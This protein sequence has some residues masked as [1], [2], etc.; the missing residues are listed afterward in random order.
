MSCNV[1][2]ASLG[3][4]KNRVDAEMMLGR[5]TDSGFR[6][7][8]DETLADV[9]IVNTCGFIESAKSESIAEILDIAK[10]KHEGN[11]KGLVVTGCLAQRY[12]GQLLLEMPEIDAVLGL[13]ANGD[14]V[15]CVN[16]V[17]RGARLE[18]FPEKTAM[19]LDGPRIL[20]T[21]NHYAY[22]RVAEG[23]DNCC[24]YCAIPLI[25]G[26][27]RSRPME[28]ILSEAEALAQ[29]GVMEFLV[30][31]QDT[32]RYGEDIYGALKLHELL[33]KLCKISSIRW[34]RLLYCY[35]DRVTDE[36]LSVISREEKIV[37]YIDI[38][39]QHCNGP[40]L[41]AMNRRGD[42]HSLLSL[43]AKMRKMIP[44]L[45]LRTTF[46]VGFPGESD[47]D[48]G[49]LIQFCREVQFERLGGFMYSAEDDTPAAKLPCQISDKEKER[50]LETLLQEQRLIAERLGMRLTGCEL[51]VIV[52]GFDDERGM[53]FGRSTMDAPEI[54]G[55]VYFAAQRDNIF[56]GEV[57]RVRVLDFDVYDLLGQEEN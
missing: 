12:Q 26:K 6:V 29:S 4:A 46:I 27:F 55:T 36:L 49:E 10:L 31:A 9:I 41:K 14:I 33:T 3:C 40:I 30:I 28:E 22:L 47:E 19:P 35:P 57:V 56:P 44:G 37:K 54:D 2:M 45:T 15:A 1:A 8:S 39:L 23:C 50:R 11:L 24:T 53:Y 51:A 38:P 7:V 16:S 34:I 43:I 18:N 52:E 13:G 25:R 17:L 42:R 32:T 5:L 48:F 20:S 21:Q